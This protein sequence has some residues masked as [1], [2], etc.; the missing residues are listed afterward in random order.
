MIQFALPPQNSFRTR[1]RST[2]VYRYQS[3]NEIWIQQKNLFRRALN[4][5]MR[6]ESKGRSKIRV[7]DMLS[8]ILASLDGYPLENGEEGRRAFR[9]F[10]RRGN[11]PVT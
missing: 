10:L 11:H 8:G 9:F 7:T 4:P 6:R 2:Y 5:T 1:P 3:A